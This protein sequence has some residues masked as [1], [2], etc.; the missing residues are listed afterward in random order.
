M[1]QNKQIKSR[2]SKE[3]R[4]SV[5]AALHVKWLV[6]LCL[7]MAP[8][9]RAQ[10]IYTA[11]D[12]GAVVRSGAT[13]YAYGVNNQ[14]Q[15]TGYTLGA[16]A[17]QP[18]IYT[19]GIG[20]VVI[21]L[22]PNCTQAMAYGINDMGH[23]AGQATVSGVNV[24]FVYSQAAGFT[25]P[26]GSAG[27]G[28]QINSIGSVVGANSLSV[29]GGQMTLLTYPRT[30]LDFPSSATSINNAGQ[31]TGHSSF[32][33]NGTWQTR[34][35]IRQ[36]TG[37]P[38][39]IGTIGSVNGSSHGIAINDSGQVAGNIQDFGFNRA[40]LYTPATGMADLGLVAGQS[41]S[42]ARGMNNNGQVLGVGDFS[43]TKIILH[44]PGIGLQHLSPVIAKPSHISSVGLSSFPIG[45]GFGNAINDYG[46]IAAFAFT[47]ISTIHAILLNPI[48]PF[49]TFTNGGAGN[50]AK[51]IAGMAYDKITPLANPT[52]GSLGS[53]VSMIGGTASE[54]KNVQVTFQ[55]GGNFAVSKASDVVDVIGTGSDLFVLQLSYDE[56]QAIALFGSEAN[57]FLSWYDIGNVP[58]TWKNA[59]LGNSNA[60]AI[61]LT[62]NQGARAFNIASDL[63]LGRY[64]VDTAA[65]RVWAVLDHNSA[66]G[67]IKQASFATWAALYPGL[68]GIN[69][70]D[71]LDGL[72]NL[73]EYALGTNPLAAGDSVPGISIDGDAIPRFIVGKGTTATLDADITYLVQFSADLKDWITHVPVIVTNDSST[74]VAEPPAGFSKGFFRLAISAT[75]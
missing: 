23:I 26:G 69:D 11:I 32:Q 65:N 8:K 60:G 47:S 48:N 70:D 25:F 20:M 2:P 58:P 9:L 74:I 10:N 16:V 28:Q 73:V 75:Q 7:L 31:I 1:K 13:A 24:A 6:L 42:Q 22:P 64:G 36:G 54:N 66:F 12:L 44:T 18:F 68:G 50:N 49:I 35:Y 56:A 43:S 61:G 45:S 34:A 41:S 30:L 59:V 52:P 29:G 40:F 63:E 71:D 19:P 17:N 67:V 62:R 38:V 37:Q 53:T 55:P 57:A 33:I 15:V 3:R 14:G 4:P 51:I 46:Q 39:N 5:F 72:V 21:P 27:Y